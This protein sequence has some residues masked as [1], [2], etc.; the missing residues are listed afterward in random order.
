[1][2]HAVCRMEGCMTKFRKWFFKTSTARLLTTGFGTVILIGA[3]LL[4][5]PI[6]HNPGHSISFLDAL[7]ESTSAVCVTGLTVV[8]PGVTFNLFGRIVLAILIQIGGM[9]VVLLGIMLIRIAGGKLGMKTRSLFVAAQNLSDYYGLQKLAMVILR[10][11]FIIEAVGALVLWIPLIRY[12]D[13]LKALGHAMFLSISAFNNAGFDLFVGGDSL[14]PYA[15]DFF[16]MMAISALVILGGFG[17][18]A[19]I[20]LAKNKCRWNKLSLTTK[21]VCVMTVSLLLGGTLLFKLTTS[22][23][24][25]QAWFQSVIAR[26]AGFASFPLSSFSQGALLIFMILM[27]IGASP[28]STGGGIKTTTAFVIGLKAVSSGAQHDE[29]SCFFRKVPNLVFTQAFTVMIY[30]IAVVMTATVLVCIA[31][32][33]LPLADVLTEVISAFATVGS[34]TGITAT[35]SS[36]SRLVIICVMFIG[37]LGPISIA[38]LLVTGS[39]KEA[40]F[41]EEN[42]LI[43]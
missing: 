30:G 22:Q 40:K 10:I 34:S 6:S 21:I 43:G 23:T 39:A 28:N 36:F 20:D 11:T 18:L 16:F 17:F 4:W 1:M 35:L 15:G 32:S 7:F 24:W 29:D 37:R 2:V 41:T 33:T 12:F 27:F 14:I 3:I 42:V 5:L 25:L 19:M 13:P 8:I 38:N 26:T 31:E 9:G